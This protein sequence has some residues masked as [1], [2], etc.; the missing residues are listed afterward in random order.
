MP[1]DK[2]SDSVN[3]VFTP[4][5]RRGAVARGSTVL[6]AAR[7]LGVDLD[8]VCGGR[9]ICGRCQVTVA[10]GN[11]AKHKIVSGP[12]SLEPLTSLEAKFDSRKG[13][14]TGRRLG[15]HARLSGDVVIDVPPES[16]VHKQV[17]RKRA[18]VRRIEMDPAIRLHYVEVEKPDMHRPTG[19]FERLTE[20]LAAQWNLHDLEEIDIRSLLRLQDVLRKG[21]WKVTV[22]VH[23]GARITKIWP[24]FHD[25]AYGIA[26]DVGSTT[27]AA[28]LCDLSTGDV[29]A[30]GGVMNPQIRFG[31][32]LMSR[33]SYLHA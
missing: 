7:A 25:R 33:I 15:C 28:H 14:Q 3:I 9:G 18:D 30:S 5:G 12:D 19:D 32:D 22:A 17:V 31:E 29:L 11:F 20:A 4:S 27:I 1:D 13:L 26:Y 6:Q 8:S 21:D 16:Q 2:A 23:R 10:E 24:G